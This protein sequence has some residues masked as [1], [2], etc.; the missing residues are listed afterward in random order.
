MMSRWVRYIVF[1][2]LATVM[3][4]CTSPSER[5][6]KQLT[7]L[8]TKVR[9]SFSPKFDPIWIAR[10][11][12]AE[13]AKRELDRLIEVM[14]NALKEVD[15]Y[16]P[17]EDMVPLHNIHKNLFED[18]RSALRKIRGEA[19]KEKPKGMAAVQIYQDMT[20]KILE[21]EECV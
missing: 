10:E 20:R 5:Y 15:R 1:L 21:V 18:C 3:A 2:C 16:K 6:E 11:K 19:D 4:S 12:K 9:Q 17:P 13:K 7:E 8:R 14:G